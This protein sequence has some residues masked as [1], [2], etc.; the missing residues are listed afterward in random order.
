MPKTKPYNGTRYSAAETLS[1][2]KINNL[3]IS[4][5]SRPPTTK[6]KFDDYYSCHGSSLDWGIIYSISFECAIDT[7]S[8]EFQYKVLNRILPFNEFLF[9][10]GKRDSSLPFFV[11]KQRKARLICFPVLSG[12]IFLE[13]NSASFWKRSYISEVGVIFGIARPLENSVLYNNLIL[14]SKQYIYI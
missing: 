8:R 13:I 6:M 12:T 10:I 11:M 4:K 7:K 9:K 14:I 1:T 5:I 2:K 3:L